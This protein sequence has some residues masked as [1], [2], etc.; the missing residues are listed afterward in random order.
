[1]KEDCVARLVK[2]QMGGNEMG[3]MGVL[4]C[5]VRTKECENKRVGEPYCIIRRKKPTLALRRWF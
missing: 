4:R 1:M 5:S 3:C 2:I